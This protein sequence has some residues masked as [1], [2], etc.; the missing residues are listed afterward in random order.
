MLIDDGII[1]VKYWFS[2]SDEQQEKR[3]KDRRKDPLRRWKLSDMDL[4]G[5]NRWIEYSKA[6]DDMFA[7]C[8]TPTSPWWDVEADDKQRA[9]INCI[10]HLLSVVPYEPCKIPKPKWSPRPKPGD[11]ERPPR[12]RY[13][14]VPDHA[15]SLGSLR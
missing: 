11:Y 15:A 2:V 14:Y 1:L 10:A 13:R 7:H 12:D 4:E 3:F 6:K 5:R 8:D 9:R